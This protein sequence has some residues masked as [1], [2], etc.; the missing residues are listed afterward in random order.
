MKTPVYGLMA[1]FESPT[2]LAAA[3]REVRE[4]G[5]RRVEAYS[6]FPIEEVNE[7]LGLHHNRLPMLV[8]MGGILGGWI[9]T[10]VLGQSPASGLLGA[11]LIAILG[12][13]IVLLVLRAARGREP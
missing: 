8:L 1:E 5:Y 6:P 9:W 13:A 2:A 7:A 3:A 10:Q 12:S 11:L 4:K